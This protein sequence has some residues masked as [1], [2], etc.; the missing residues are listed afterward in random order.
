MPRPKT[1]HQLAVIT[2]RTL[3]DPGRHR[4][5]K[6]PASPPLG[7]PSAWMT[8][9]QKVAFRSIK[10]ELFWLE[11]ADR[12]LV[13]IA[14]CLRARLQS[15]EEVGVNAL[16]SL[17]LCLSQMGA[18]P[19]DRGKVRVLPEDGDRPTRRFFT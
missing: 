7:N 11:E 18:T 15:G 4:G 12:C 8:K 16:N 6:G 5:G 3:H 9:A 2:G 10:K 19:A 1:P 17:R 14:A 13:E